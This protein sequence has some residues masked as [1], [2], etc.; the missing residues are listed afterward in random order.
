MKRQLEVRSEELGVKRLSRK[1][2]NLKNMQK[3]S[4][5]AFTL[6]E[7]LTAVT[8]TGMLTVLALAPVAYTVRN[9][10]ETQNEYA[11]FSALSRTLNFIIRDL[12]SA[13]RLSSNVLM[14]VDHKALGGNE[15]DILMIMSTSPTA[16]NLPSG[17]LIYKTAEG[18]IMHGNVLPGLYRWMFPGKL[19]NT[20][21]YD[22]LDAS[23]GQL[24]LPGI[25]LFSVE[26]PDGSNEEDRRK[27]YSGALPKGLYIK[28][29]RNTKN[30]SAQSILSDNNANNFN[31]LEAYIP[32]P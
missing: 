3:R 15:D 31:E 17:T 13:M 23:E 25:D 11:D 20:I 8:L 4:R 29:G 1:Y 32:L 24:V 28:M 18:G 22:N 16:Q 6:I 5:S 9:V 21:K 19:P 2:I 7:V 26:V 14:I 10:V 30:N 27:E 12:S